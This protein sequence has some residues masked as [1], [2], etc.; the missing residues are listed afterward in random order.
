MY[1]EGNLWMTLNLLNLLFMNLTYN[2]STKITK[3][4]VRENVLFC[5][6]F[7]KIKK[8]EL[9]GKCKKFNRRS[10]NDQ[11]FVNKMCNRETKTRF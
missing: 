9:V 2:R 1:D 3:E 11:T 10:D 5:I 8:M 7:R 6:S 4:N